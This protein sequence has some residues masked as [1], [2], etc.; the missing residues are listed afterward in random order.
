MHYKIYFYLKPSNHHATPV[1][2]GSNARNFFRPNP[3][4]TYKTTAAQPIKQRLINYLYT[5]YTL[6]N[7]YHLINW[8]CI[9]SPAHN[10]HTYNVHT[11][12][13]TLA[14]KL[15][16]LDLVLGQNLTVAL[17][18]GWFVQSH[19]LIE[20]CVPCLHIALQPPTD[21]RIAA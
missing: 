17:S 2:I 19:G 10:S 15:R 16:P 9:P 3:L 11:L 21:H 4:T 14:Y 12:A 6:S 20:H 7:Q 8:R 5:L 1:N 18:R 13:G